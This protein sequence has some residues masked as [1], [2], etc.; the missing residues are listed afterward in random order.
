M[1]NN[2]VSIKK[3]FTKGSDDKVKALVFFQ[4]TCIPCIAEHKL[5]QD[6]LTEEEKKQVILMNLN[7]TKIP[8]KKYLNLGN[9]L[10]ITIK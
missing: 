8:V 7:E 3:L 2:I 9:I 5:M 10:Q 6:I 4:T 1:N